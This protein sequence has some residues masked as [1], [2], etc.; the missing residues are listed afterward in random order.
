MAKEQNPSHSGADDVSTVSRDDDDIRA[1]LELGDAALERLSVLET[2]IADE[3]LEVLGRL[4]VAE[5]TISQIHASTSW[6][7]AG[8]VRAIGRLIRRRS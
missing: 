1:R 3:M 2:G 4:E 6:K 8:G 7:L 5:R